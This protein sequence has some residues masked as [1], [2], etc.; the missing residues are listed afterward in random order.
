M[1]RTVLVVHFDADCWHSVDG[2]LDAKWVSG[3][4]SLFADWMKGEW[5]GRRTVQW[6]LYSE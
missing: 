4:V 6:L 2:I 1:I 3:D 5:V